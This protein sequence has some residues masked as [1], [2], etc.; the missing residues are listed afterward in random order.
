MG[1]G[2][3]VGVGV[4]VEVGVG[5]TVGVCVGVEVGVAVGV[6]VGIGVHV[7]V[8]VGVGMRVAV[9]VGVKV[10]VRTGPGVAV[11]S[12][13]AVGDGVLAGLRQPMTTQAKANEIAMIFQYDSEFRGFTEF[14]AVNSVNPFNSLSYRPNSHLTTPNKKIT[15]LQLIP[16][17]CPHWQGL[18]TYVSLTKYLRCVTISAN[19]SIIWTLLSRGVEGPAL[20]NPGN[21]FGD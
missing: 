5:V 19:N 21:R 1:V 7:E 10:R 13:I 17:L 14:G 6:H 16:L 2:V 8:G 18:S 15:I 3:S 11:G 9:R 20:R 4:R 12:G